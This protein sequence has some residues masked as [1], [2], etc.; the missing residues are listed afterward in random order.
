MSTS[1]IHDEIATRLHQSW[2]AWILLLSQFAVDGGGLSIPLEVAKLWSKLAEVQFAKLPSDV[3][4]TYYAD[5]RS[6]LAIVASHLIGV[7]P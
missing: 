3:R 1:L 5:A 7:K 2:A 4:D 6:L